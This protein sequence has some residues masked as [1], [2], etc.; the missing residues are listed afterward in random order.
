[1]TLPV[2]DI[3]CYLVRR[4]AFGDLVDSFNFNW[5]YFAHNGAIE[6]AA[7]HLQKTVERSIVSY[8]PNEEQLIEVCGRVE[9]LAED[10]R[11]AYLRNSIAA[12]NNTTRDEHSRLLAVNY[13]NGDVV[14]NIL[15]AMLIHDKDELMH[16][17]SLC[18]LRRFV[19]DVDRNK[20]RFLD[21]KDGIHAVFD[22]LDMF[23]RSMLL[24]P[25][26]FQILL[27]GV[28]GIWEIGLNVKAARQIVLK[29]GIAI[30]TDIFQRHIKNDFTAA[31]KYLDD[32]KSGAVVPEAMKPEE[33]RKKREEDLK[34]KQTFLQESLTAIRVIA[35]QSAEENASIEDEDMTDLQIEQN[36][37]AYEVL[38]STLEFLYRIHREV[39]FEYS[40]MAQNFTAQ[41]LKILAQNSMIKSEQDVYFIIEKIVV[42]VGAIGVYDSNVSLKPVFTLCANSIEFGRDVLRPRLVITPSA[43]SIAFYSFSMETANLIGDLLDTVMP[44]SELEFCTRSLDLISMLLRDLRSLCE[45]LN[46]LDPIDLKKECDSYQV[47]EYVGFVIENF[48]TNEHRI[49]DYWTANNCERVELMVDTFSLSV[50]ANL[51]HNYEEGISRSMAVLYLLVTMFHSEHNAKMI[52]KLKAD[53][54]FIDALKSVALKVKRGETKLERL[55]DEL[56]SLRNILR[57]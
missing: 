43:S 51:K 47:S 45:M 53:A 50:V 6:L 2:A 12:L 10:L 17:Y 33:E 31:R 19:I 29:G 14:R 35:I 1:M 32:L 46:Q 38:L 5:Q 30:L 15:T 36:N 26:N 55:P 24:F 44:E 52:S 27:D 11:V 54:A 56:R 28:N 25:D 34:K 8:G 3:M 13:D 22:P 23:L 49:A 57:M 41:E 20:L 48:L 21:L 4:M 42:S 18:A 37:E 9:G 40:A 39:V 7:R 16:D